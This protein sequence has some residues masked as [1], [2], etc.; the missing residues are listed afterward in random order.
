MRE[1][2]FQSPGGLEETTVRGRDGEMTA[3][4]AAQASEMGV[5][6]GEEKRG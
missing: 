5:C 3:R 1:K 4:E 2:R 6:R